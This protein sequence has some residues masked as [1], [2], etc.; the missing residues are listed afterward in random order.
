MAAHNS[1]KQ[2]FLAYGG[3]VLAFI[4]MFLGQL[5]AT[6]WTVGLLIIADTITGMWAAKKRGEEL[7]SR[8]G[9]RIFAKILIYPLVVIVAKA[10]ETYLTPAIPWM[11]VTSGIIAV[12]EVKSIFENASDILGYDLWDRIRK[13]MWKDRL[14]IGD[15]KDEKDANK[16]K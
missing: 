3:E 8:K 15:K 5:E 7:T 14:D 13:G 11:S 16:D 4:L 2:D 12:V 1:L 9:G 10:A 6:L